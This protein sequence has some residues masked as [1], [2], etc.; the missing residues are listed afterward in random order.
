MRA[1]WSLLVF[2]VVAC[3]ARVAVVESAD[4]TGAHADSGDDDPSTSAGMT[5][6][7][8]TDAESGS[9]EPQ[10]PAT[11][12]CDASCVVWERDYQGPAGVADNFSGVAVGPDGTI[13]AVGM[14]DWVQDA[15]AGDLY[16]VGYSVGG[17][18]LWE[19]TPFGS[20]N[21]EQDTATGVAVGPDGTIA[22]VGWRWSG[23]LTSAVLAIIGEDPADPPLIWLGDG[24]DA[25]AVTFAEDGTVFVGG[26]RFTD[27]GL[28]KAFVERYTT[29][30]VVIEQWDGDALGL[31][32]G[33]ILALT[34]LPDG[35]IA[36]SGTS[37]ASGDGDV[38]FGML[39]VDTGMSWSPIFGESNAIAWADD[40]AL[41]P[42]GDVILVGAQYDGENNALGW[43]GRFAP[44]GSVRW[45]RTYAGDGCCTNA[46][47]NVEVTDDGRV[48]V[49]GVRSRDGG[50]QIK[51]QE[52]DC[53]GEIVWEWNHA[54]SGWN[55]AFSG[56][57]AW[58]PSVGL[59]VAGSDYPMAD[60]QRGY[61]ARF[62]L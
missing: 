3:S 6:A 10:C 32:N 21:G 52:L 57:L 54:S 5:T 18:L 26:T 38:W 1:Q 48:M 15:G 37:S 33:S 24:A 53:D 12:V 47:D 14:R 41:L 59:V 62:G 60:D 46:L 51:L 45:S 43:A 20:N 23:G 25:S 31:P 40:I 29:G 13:V 22:V 19:L 4:G 44:D 34:T 35:V 7:S 56:G 11:G 50:L 8:P 30:G 9:V 61:L 28:Q 16:V 49:L 36:M 27:R 39:D 58:H 55:T 17:D 2:A 42:D